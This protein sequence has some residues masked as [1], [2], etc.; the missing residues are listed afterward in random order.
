MRRADHRLTLA[1][2][3]ERS[4]PRPDLPPA[5]RGGPR[6]VWVVEPPSMPGKHPGLLIE[7]RKER[8]GWYGLTVYVVETSSGRA[9]VQE[10]LPAVYL[11][12]A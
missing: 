9:T 2:R 5:D 12:P 11:E 3:L 6:H 8:D 10:W 7:W 1:E 4:R